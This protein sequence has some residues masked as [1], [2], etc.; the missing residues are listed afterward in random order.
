MSLLRSVLC[1]SLG[2][3]VAL[4]ARLSAA[5][6]SSLVPEVGYNYGEIESARAT[7]M[8]GAMRALGNG[9]TALYSNP[10]G[11]TLTRVYHLEGM[12]AIWPESRRQSYGAAAVDSV[13]GRLAGGLAGQYG[14]LDPDGIQRK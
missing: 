9:T 7:A 3:A 14:S 13:T 10:A 1:G 4:V 5:D 2:I 11:M 8:G 12:A 6:P